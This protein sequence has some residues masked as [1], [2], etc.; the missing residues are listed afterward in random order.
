MADQAKN[1]LNKNK[2]ECCNRLTNSNEILKCQLCKKRYHYT[3]VTVITTTLY[4]NL[5]EDFKSTW[6][7]PSCNRPRPGTDNTS[8]PVRSFPDNNQELQNNITL[9]RKQ[10][11]HDSNDGESHSLTLA[12]VRRAIREE[13]VNTLENF[14]TNVMSQLNI[15]TKEVLDQLVQVTDSMNF[16]EQQYEDLKKEISAKEKVI[17]TLET[18]CKNLQT[19]VNELG[20]RLVK[21]EQHS[22]SMNVE[23]HCVPEHKNENLMTLVKQ[24]AIT[25]N[26]KLN[27]SNIHYCTRVAKLQN[28]S[29]RPRS[30]LIKFS[31]P[32]IRDEFL[33]ASINF[34][35][36]AK[37]N[38]EKMNTN[39][40]GIRDDPKPIYVVEHLSPTQKSLHAAARL[41]AKELKYRF[42]WVRGGNIYMRKTETSEYKFIR[43]I[44]TL[45]TLI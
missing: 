16:I 37:N 32:R 10:E 6:L 19:S 40:I 29:P 45:S 41:K 31:S 28:N 24:I 43:N 42:V 33:A 35:K 25:T 30:I 34:N 3:C 11:T 8:T 5:S 39:H 21:I 26:Y 23:I 36:K 2:F 12:D 9:R 14:K 38:S 7:C 18:E 17:Q 44:E 27:E 15:K 20:A 22:R 1:A 13:L 4:K